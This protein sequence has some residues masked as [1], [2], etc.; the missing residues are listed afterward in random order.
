[1]FKKK[2]GTVTITLF[3]PANDDSATADGL[4]II[5]KNT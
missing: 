2:D 5:E 1:M 4:Q 3:Q